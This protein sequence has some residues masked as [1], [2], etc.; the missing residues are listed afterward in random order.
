[1]FGD[2]QAGGKDGCLV[3]PQVEAAAAGAAPSSGQRPLPQLPGG[4]ECDAEVVR[5][6]LVGEPGRKAT[7]AV[8]RDDIG[9]E[10]NAGH[11]RSVA[12]PGTLLLAHLLDEQPELF[13]LLVGVEQVTPRL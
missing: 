10:G 5:G 9:V 12:V 6:D 3:E 2:H 1:M 11:V 7:R 4:G 13:H 8:E